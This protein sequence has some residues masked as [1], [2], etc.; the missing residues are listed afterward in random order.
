MNNPAEGLTSSAMMASK[1]L[2]HPPRRR[3]KRDFDIESV[4]HKARLR[5]LPLGAL[6]RLHAIPVCCASYANRSSPALQ[7]TR[8]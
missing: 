7:H 3:P 4:R 6:F 5:D 2:E 1:G 8:L